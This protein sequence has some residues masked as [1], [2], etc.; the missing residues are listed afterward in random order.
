MP[1]NGVIPDIERIGHSLIALGYFRIETQI[2][3]K[4]NKISTARVKYILYEHF[5]DG[6]K[7]ESI[8]RDCLLAECHRPTNSTAVDILGLS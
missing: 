8:R 4:Y 2:C 5:S 3:D 6:T 7:A 1:K